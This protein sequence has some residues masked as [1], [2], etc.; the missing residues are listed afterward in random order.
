MLRKKNEQKH[1]SEEKFM[2]RETFPINPLYTR[3][4]K[5]CPESMHYFQQNFSCC[6]GRIFEML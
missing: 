5:S 3:K 1:E 6:E 2:L 4:K